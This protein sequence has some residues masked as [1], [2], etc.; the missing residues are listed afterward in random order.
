VERHG[1]REF[2]E[3]DVQAGAAVEEM[4]TRSGEALFPLSTPGVGH[5]A[6]KRDIMPPER[7]ELVA[8]W[9]AG[10]LIVEERLHFLK[11]GAEH[12]P[13]LWNIRGSRNLPPTPSRRGRCTPS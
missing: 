2:I 12:I 5:S 9:L 13:S 1:N 7:H 11:R 4:D 3:Q 6:T 8:L 10:L